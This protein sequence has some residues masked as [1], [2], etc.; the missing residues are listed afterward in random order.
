LS[1]I[2]TNPHHYTKRLARNESTARQNAI[3]GD[4]AL[5]C[6]NFAGNVG[7]SRE[8]RRYIARYQ[9]RVGLHFST[10]RRAYF[11]R[12]AKSVRSCREWGR[13]IDGTSI[14]TPLSKR[15]VALHGLHH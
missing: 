4:A 1:I 10:S 11:E 9:R 3:T 13:I 14:S 6:M 15:P 5:F 8:T 2:A 12:I 7:R